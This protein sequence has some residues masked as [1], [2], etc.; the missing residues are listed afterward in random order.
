MIKPFTTNYS[1]RKDALAQFKARQLAEAV[2][3]IRVHAG[4]RRAA[5]PLSRE[6]A[7]DRSNRIGG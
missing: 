5:M 7:W 2:E 3:A 6:A 4:V 1:E